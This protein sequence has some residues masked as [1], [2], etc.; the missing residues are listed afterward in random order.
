MGLDM[1]SP[2]A[3]SESLDRDGGAAGASPLPPPPYAG[4]GALELRGSL[5]CW[6][7]AVLVTVQ[8]L[9][10]GTLNL[11]LV[12]AIF[13]LILLPAGVLVGFGVLC[14]SKF[15]HTQV[16]Y[17]TAH[18]HDAASVA[19]LV[20]GFALAVP[21]LVLALAAYCRLARRLQLGYC[22]VPYSKAV[23][24]N[25]PVTHYHN[26]GCCSCA[27]DLDSGEKVWV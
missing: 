5:D 3:T 27:P 18:L 12:G 8:N 20:V 24:K 26:S 6:A 7:C 1:R 16:H 21:L 2:K 14:H 10:V 17:C 25:L 9:L 4:E 23:Y 15:L 19:L 22:L 13:G 11:L